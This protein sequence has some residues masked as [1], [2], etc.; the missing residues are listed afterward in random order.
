MYL[1]KWQLTI[2]Y[3]IKQNLKSCYKSH[4]KWFKIHIFY[5]FGTDTFTLYL[6][7]VIK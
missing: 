5:S 7:G 6:R 3:W 4:K 1:V 2:K